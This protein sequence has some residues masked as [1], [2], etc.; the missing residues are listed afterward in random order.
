VGEAG[1]TPEGATKPSRLSSVQ[2]L[3]GAASV[4]V[5]LYHSARHVDKAIGA[6]GLA[7]AFRSGHAGVDL[8][9]VISG[10]IILFVHRQDIGRPSRL[11]R[12]AGRRFSRVL[13]LYWIA[14]VITLVMLALGH[15]LP[16]P[17]WILWCATLLPTGPDPLMGHA[18]T[19]QSEIVFYAV[20]A[21]LILDRRAGVVVLL[22]WLACMG[23]SVAGLF[24]PHM[25][26]ALVR[27]YG[28]EFFLGMAVVIAIWHS[29]F[30]PAYSRLAPLMAG[31]GAV[32][33]A[34][35]MAA[36]TEGW[37][38]GEAPFARLT[39]GVPAAL[40]VAGLA[41]WERDGG[42]RVP[43]WLLALGEASYSVYLFQFIFIGAMW[44]AWRWA[45][46]THL[47]PPAGCFVVLAAAAILGGV[48]TSKLV[49]RPLLRIA[50]RFT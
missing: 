43:R 23:A 3:R 7:T 47:V 36:E 16:G 22:A 14:Y 33:F 34:A 10:F 44:Q 28:V 50:R 5:V 46:L 21:V 49:E 26:Q 40:L 25:P 32:L 41:A 31:A 29:A 45:G 9:F 15:G 38:D 42:L 11:A 30:T 39:Y 6:P 17:G 37:L 24:P 35:A 20:F 18:W 12:Y 19:L 1:V 8:F 48:A 2:A 13:P 4:A 27:V